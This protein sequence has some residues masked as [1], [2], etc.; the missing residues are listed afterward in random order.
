[1]PLSPREKAAG[2]LVV[3]LG[4]NLPPARSADQDAD[5]VAALLDRHPV[6]GLILFNG[7]WPDTRET[8]VRLQRHSDAGLLV[9]TDMERGFGQQ[10]LGATVY[11]HAGAFARLPD[12]DAAEA[13]RTYAEQ[14]SGEALAGGVHVTYSPVADVDRNPRNPI[15]G[16]RAYGPDPERA[17][18]LVTAFVEGVHAAGQIATAKH[19]PGHGGTSEDSHATTPSVDDPRDVLEA[20]DLVPFR[21]AVAAGVDAVMTAHV[22][23]PALDPSGAIATRSAPILRGLLRD[24]MGFGGVVVTDSLQMAGAKEAGRTE[25]D[26]AAELLLAGVDLFVDAVDPE[27][28][29]EGV[30]RA[31]EDG[32]LDEALLDAALARVQR[33]RERLTARFGAGVFRDPGLAYA[34]SVVGLP[35]HRDLAERVAR[36]AVELATG[37]LPAD[38]GDGTGVVV[39]AF[40]RPPLPIEPSEM[41]LRSAVA[42]HLPGATYCE[43]MPSPHSPDADV[44]AVRSLARGARRVV[45]APVIRPSAWHAFGLAAREAALA[46]E[47]AA[48]VPT[49]LLLLGD[50]RGLAGFPL[51]DSALVAYSDVAAS[52]RALVERLVGA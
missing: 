25:G 1:M 47:I 18:A 17:A 29:V 50:R 44:E 51:A 30:G 43:L 38:L 13:V 39:V 11:P 36:G 7:R 14:S 46:D 42:Q 31:V 20:T 12:P 22:A 9:T 4:N 3:R 23:V 2:L 32:R 37:P 19:F 34:S 8:L 33:L 35:E 6:G 45:L 24:E 49:T 48:T 52:Q 10:A 26:L 27:A 41:A 16:T 21:A 15:I 5:A 28:L 40:R